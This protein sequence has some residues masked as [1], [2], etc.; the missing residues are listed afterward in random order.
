MTMNF[1]INR[2]IAL[3]LF[4]VVLAGVAV[5]Q[6]ALGPVTG[7]VDKGKDLYY[8][9][10]CYG[11]HGYNGIGRKNLANDV[12]GIMSNEQVFLIYLRAR[13]DQ[14]PLFPTQSMPNYPVTSL[15]DE[16]ARDIYAYIRTF[17][18]SPPDVEDIPALQGILDAAED[19]A[20]KE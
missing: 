14:N 20:A 16:Q 11:C 15:P 8:A 17:K 7:D 3:T 13:E 4:S 9:Q 2:T 19:A 18:D 10:G 12:S 1:Q 5:A 6:V